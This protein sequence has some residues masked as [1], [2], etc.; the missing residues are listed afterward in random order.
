ML[1]GVA[2]LPWIS[3][4][5]GQITQQRFFIANDCVTLTVMFL[6][7]I[8]ASLPVSVAEGDTSSEVAANAQAAPGKEYGVTY[9]A[10]CRFSGL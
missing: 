1:C 4:M 10:A 2:A 5:H 7:S 3:S 9:N 6:C 8:F